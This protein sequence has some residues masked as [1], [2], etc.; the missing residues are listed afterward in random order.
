MNTTDTAQVNNWGP[1]PFTIEKV[2]F[3]AGDVTQNN[4]LSSIDAQKIQQNFVNGTPFTRPPWTFWNA[5]TTIS[6]NPVSAP[7]YP[8][9]NLIAGNDL[10]VNMYGLCTG[11]FN[12]S[13]NPLSKKSESKTLSLI[14]GRSMH[15]KSNEEFDLPVRL[16]NASSVGALSLILE[17]PADLVEVK[18]V[19]MH[20]V[21]GELD[22]AVF[23]QAHSRS[24]SA[25]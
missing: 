10:T 14:Y 11:D 6:S 12:R 8:V 3:Y 16:V 5:G 24:R 9:V 7:D 19:L 21:N 2:R 15:V 23:D 18:N 4:F 25:E 20:S 1:H 22:W 17:F 13:F